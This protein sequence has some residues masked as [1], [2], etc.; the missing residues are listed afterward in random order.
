MRRQ[1]RHQA[2]TVRDTDDATVQTVRAGIARVAGE[3]AL[4]DAQRGHVG[5]QLGQCEGAFGQARV[6][7][8]G[9]LVHDG[10]DFFPQRPLGGKGFRHHAEVAAVRGEDVVARVAFDL[11]KIRDA[12]VLERGLA[13]EEWIKVRHDGRRAER[14]VQD[15]LGDHRHDVRLA[16][17]DEAALLVK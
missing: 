13:H 11:G 17:P 4:D 15:E 6:N 12:L 14:A 16:T 5:V 8:A 3:F 10:E 9:V 7:G 1:F 2:V